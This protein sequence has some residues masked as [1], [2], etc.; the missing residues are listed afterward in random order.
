MP[1]SIPASE[2]MMD[3]QA[4]HDSDTSRHSISRVCRA[5]TLF[6]RHFLIQ[7]RMN[8]AECGVLQSIFTPRIS[9]KRNLILMSN[10]NIENSFHVSAPCVHSSLL[11][12]QYLVET[13]ATVLQL[14]FISALRA[15]WAL[16]QPSNG[17]PHGLR[18]RCSGR[19]DDTREYVTTVDLKGRATRIEQSAAAGRFGEKRNGPTDVVDFHGRKAECTLFR[20]PSSRKNRLSI[21]A[22]ADLV[23]T[24]QAHRSSNRPAASAAY[25]LRAPA[26]S[27][28]SHPTA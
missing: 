19:F 4:V 25:Q 3:R 2:L 22:D 9:Y 1:S 28:L 12:H 18:C 7:W 5:S 14:D 8:T 6:I 27:L 24:Q 16:R 23:Q 20:P 17:M 15:Y 26:L 11:R 10:L 21:Q 13:G